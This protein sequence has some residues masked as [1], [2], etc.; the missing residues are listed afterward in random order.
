MTDDE[1]V[2]AWEALSL[3]FD[4]WTHRAHVKVALTYLRRHSFPEALAKMRLG[5]KAFNARNAVPENLTRGYNET[6]THSFMHL[7]LATMRAYGSF[8]TPD[9]DSFCDTH[10]QL[11]TRHCL[12]HFYSPEQRMHPLAKTQFVEP[13]L[14]PLPR[15]LPLAEAVISSERPDTPDAIA[16]ITELQTHLES[17]YPP[18]SRHGF[19][20]ER[21]IAESVAFFLLRVRG[22]AAGCGGI[23]LF[24]CE[25]G[26]IKRMYVRPQFRGRGFGTLILDRLADYARTQGVHLLRL[27]TG[28]HQQAAIRLYEQ[29]GFR[30]TP[31]FGPYTNSPGSLCYEKQL[32]QE[33]AGT[34]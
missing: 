33:V 32:G 3:P 8:P 30:K 17:F 26:E 25:Y 2:K 15:I 23:K 16:L 4:Q 20:V 1:L 11:M 22:E 31:R 28:I 10:P 34:T 19:S 12:R 29:A 27:E 5:V 9:G 18:E 6:T 13:D 7:I 24:G 14:A 21:L